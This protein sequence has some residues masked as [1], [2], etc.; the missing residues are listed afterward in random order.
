MR[1]QILVNSLIKLTDMSSV[2][3]PVL[4]AAEGLPTKGGTYLF[5][6][7]NG[8]KEV[9]FNPNYK[10]CVKAVKY[11]TYWYREVFTVSKTL[12]KRAMNHWKKSKDFHWNNGIYK[13]G[14][15]DNLFRDVIINAY[16][17]GA[18]E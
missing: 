10:E 2:L 8:K 4:I 7:R 6:N 11:Y 1:C 14:V 5:S 13:I 3:Y 16:K 17:S 12:H 9:F 15:L 18:T